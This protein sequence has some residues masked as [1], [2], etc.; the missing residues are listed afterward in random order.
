MIGGLPIGF[1]QPLVLIGLLTLPVLWWL[2]RL[3]PPR[4]RRLDFPTCARPVLRA[5]VTSSREKIADG[6]QASSRLVNNVSSS[7]IPRTVA[8]T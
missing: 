3:I 1:A 2:L 7:A 5:E 6:P 8:L 4:P